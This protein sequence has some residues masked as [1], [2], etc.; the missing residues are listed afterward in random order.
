M[1]RTRNWYGSVLEGGYSS[2]PFVRTM[3]ERTDHSRYAV[4][5]PELMNE[6]QEKAGRVF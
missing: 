5:D 2:G 4:G 1:R 3:Q 6:S